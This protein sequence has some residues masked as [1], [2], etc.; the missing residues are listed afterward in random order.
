M[1]R[2]QTVLP[3]HSVLMLTDTS[4]R[5]HLKTGDSHDHNRHHQADRRAKARHHGLRKKTPVFMGRH[6]LENFVQSIFD[7]VGGQR[8]KPLFWAATGAI[9]TTAPRR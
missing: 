5:Q 4:F 2:R 9:S 6:Y 1:A 8:A 3:A 7:V